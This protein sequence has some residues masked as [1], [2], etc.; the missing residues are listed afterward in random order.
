MKGEIGLES[1]PGKGTTFTFTLPFAMP[2]AAPHRAAALPCPELANKKV[3][4]VDDKEINRTLLMQILPRWGLRPV[5]AKDGPQALEIFKKSVEERAPFSLLLLDQNMP[6]MHGFDVAGR[7]R[8]VAGKERPAI[9]ILSS[10]PCLTDPQ[11]A[12]KLGIDRVLLKPLRRATLHE[13]IRHALKLPTPFEKAPIH[14]DEFGKARGL[15]VLLVEDNRV[16]QKLALSLLGKMGHLATLAINGREAVELAQMN[17]FDL[18]LMDIQMP[19][20]GGV[21]ATQR[22]REAERKTGGHLPI[23]ALTAHAM[24]GDAEKYVSA[25]MD[26]YL[27]KPVESNL[28]QAEIGRLAKAPVHEEKKAVQENAGTSLDFDQGELLARVDNDRELLHDLLR[29]FKEEVPLQLQAL[30]EAVGS[31][32]AKRVAAAAHTMKGMLSNLAAIQSAA[33]AERLEQLGRSEEKQDFPEALAAFESDIAR[34]LPQ[35]DACM[36]EVC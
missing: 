33:S 6:G 25:G 32:D 8:L 16:N 30:R 21:E 4:V 7:I 9:I 23:V 20:M 26:G 19:V 14:D 1:S 11:R 17:S 12:M 18:V 36:A 3:L 5:S 29:I 24:A 31:G 15:R 28:L 35:L 22:I 10:A 2:K 27:S 13:A 34:L